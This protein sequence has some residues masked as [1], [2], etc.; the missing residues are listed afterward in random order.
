MS[1]DRSVLVRECRDILKNNILSFWMKHSVNTGKSSFFGEIDRNGK[2]NPDAER[3]GIL[4]SRILWAFSAG[5]NSLKDPEYLKIAEMA[6][7]SLY[8]DFW[9][10]EFG[11]IYFSIDSNG[12]PLNTSKMTDCQCYAIYG[13]NEF[14]TATRRRDVFD[15]ACEIIGFLEG[16]LKDSANGGYVSSLNNDYSKDKNT[17]YSLKTLNA[18]VHVI[19]SCTAYL[20]NNG[21][22]YL[23]DIVSDSFDIIM[24]FYQGGYFSY[25]ANENYTEF[26]KYTWYGLNL[27]TAW[28]LYD[29]ALTLSDEK[30]ISIAKNVLIESC[31][32]AILN[33]VDSDG[34]IYYEGDADTVKVFNK[35]GWPQT[36]AMIAFSYA[37][38][39]TADDKY[40]SAANSS[41]NFLKENIIDFE[42]G[43]WI[44]GVDKERK[45]LGNPLK[46][47]F[48]KCPYHN[49]RG[50]LKMMEILS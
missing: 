27:E 32:W 18:Q 41:F 10:K 21:S 46:A 6:Y 11:G 17:D 23:K 15:L 39:I 33:A 12:K 49:T 47:G 42:N 3:G 8:A 13:I 5:Y 24:K 26:S 7:D 30:R 48:W 16:G 14:F 25:S 31:D 22:D 44:N 2:A 1:V 4:Q 45:D 28:F 40:L 29:A 34:G 50:M 37:Y 38:K 20:K 19:E 43:E 9:D 36:E 35:E